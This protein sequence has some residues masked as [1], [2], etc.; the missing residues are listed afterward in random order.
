MEQWVIAGAAFVVIVSTVAVYEIR[1]ARQPGDDDYEP[2]ETGVRPEGLWVLP[3][4]PSN[5]PMPPVQP[6]KGRRPF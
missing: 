5:I 3:P 2:T 6:T 4:T 1:R